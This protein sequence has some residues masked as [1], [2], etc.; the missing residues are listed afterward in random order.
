VIERPPRPL[1]PNRSNP[2][3]H[4][5]H[6]STRTRTSSTI[7]PSPRAKLRWGREREGVRAGGENL[8]GIWVDR[9]R[10]RG[11]KGLGTRRKAPGGMVGRF[12][13]RRSF[14]R[15]EFGSGVRE[16]TRFFPRAHSSATVTDTPPPPRRA[17]R[18][19]RVVGRLPEMTTPSRVRQG[20]CRRRRRAA[21]AAA[22]R[23]SGRRGRRVRWLGGLSAV[24]GESSGHKPR[25]ISLLGPAS[26]PHPGGC[27]AGR[28][29]EAGAPSCR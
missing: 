22:A 20:L 23:A 29:V 26:W 12:C 13:A 8:A 9:R 11:T 25:Y 14:W 10:A 7:S 28:P 24:E 17:A 15:M 2:P 3:K 27:S 5:Y 21:R 6:I 16:P 1:R 19:V 18:H 4:I